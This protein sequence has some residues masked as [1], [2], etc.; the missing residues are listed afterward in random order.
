MFIKTIW[1]TTMN[2][3]YLKL[4]FSNIIVTVVSFVLIIISK[5]VLYQRFNDWEIY[6]NAD[7]IF[8]IGSTIANMLLFR[9]F[10]H[11]PCPVA[12]A[13]DSLF[14][15]YCA[16]IYVISLVREN[17]FVSK[18]YI[19]VGIILFMVVFSVEVIFGANAQDKKNKQYVYEQIPY[20]C[21]NLGYRGR[22]L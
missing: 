3:R 14:C 11:I 12:T 1:K 16:L 8:L 7:I 22:N 20:G 2:S 19:F 18:V 4:F 6:V 10:E 13:L 17:D 9:C 5:T 21:I 15:A